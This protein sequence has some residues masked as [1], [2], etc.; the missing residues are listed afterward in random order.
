MKSE[1]NRGHAK[2]GH[3]GRNFEKG[4]V[5]GPP[6]LP[7]DVSS[8]DTQV[9]IRTQKK[10]KV[11]HRGTPF[12]ALYPGFFVHTPWN[13]KQPQMVYTTQGAQCENTS[14]EGH[15]KMHGVWPLEWPS[16]LKLM[17]VRV[18]VYHK[19]VTLTLTPCKNTFGP[20]GKGYSSV[21]GWP[22]IFAHN[23]AI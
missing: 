14:R 17:Y 19:S 23:P 12:R 16:P 7:E 21:C 20:I 10:A 13:P 22:S 6:R 9:P 18:Q 4:Q 5:S 8:E 3:R 15:P 2:F 1:D 11:S